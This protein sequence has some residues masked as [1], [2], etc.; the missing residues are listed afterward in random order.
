MPATFVLK[1]GSTGKFRFNLI[2]PN[3][4]SIATSEAYETKASAMAGIASVRK[5]AAG[6]TVVDQTVVAATPA[7]PVKPAARKK[8]VAR[9]APAKKATKTAPARKAAKATVKKAAAKRR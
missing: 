3:G 5:N 8:P 1:R 7:Q 9:T 2:A 4:Q 6:A